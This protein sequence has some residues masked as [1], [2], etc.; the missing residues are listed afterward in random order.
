MPRENPIANQDRCAIH[1]GKQS[2]DKLRGLPIC[3]ECVRVGLKAI[4]EQPPPP[5]RTRTRR[6]HPAAPA[7]PPGLLDAGQLDTRPEPDA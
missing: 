5:P 3:A 4:T 7:A 6:P 1:P 2:V